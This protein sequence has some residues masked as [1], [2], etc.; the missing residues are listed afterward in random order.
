MCTQVVRL[1]MALFICGC[2][3]LAL[4]AKALTMPSADPAAAAQATSAAM[5][6]TLSDDA[7]QDEQSRPTNGDAQADPSG[8]PCAGLAVLETALLMA[9]P[10]VLAGTALRSRHPDGL[11]R[12]PCRAVTAA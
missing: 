5:G 4:P 2:G 3:L 10:P 7:V 1:F 8:P 6:D 11:Q 9:R 12:P